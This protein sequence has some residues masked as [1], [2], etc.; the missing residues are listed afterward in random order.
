M[1][2]CGQIVLMNAEGC[3]II[4]KGR[5]WEEKNYLFPLPSD[6]LQLNPNLQQNPGWE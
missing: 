1:K 5:K 4:E 6:Q 2:K 3:I